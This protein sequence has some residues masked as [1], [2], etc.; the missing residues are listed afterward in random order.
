MTGRRSG[1]HSRLGRASVPRL[2]Q[3]GEAT[4]GWQL[5]DVASVAG[6]SKD[7]IYV[8]MGSVDGGI[9]DNRGI[10]SSPTKNTYAS[11]VLAVK[12]GGQISDGVDRVCL[13][14][15][16]ELEVVADRKR[17]VFLKGR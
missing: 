5:T 8:F 13:F 15:R 16:S 2:R 7:C 3:L 11:N 14:L 9:D 17:A 4:D 10:P 12:W 1:S 6:G